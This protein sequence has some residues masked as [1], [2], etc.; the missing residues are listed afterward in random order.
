MKKTGICAALAAG[1]FVIA[2]CDPYAYGPAAGGPNQ[3]IGTIGGA[4]AGGLIGNQI[5]KG[6]GRA[7]ATTIGVIAGGLIGN[8]IG[9]NLDELD[10]RRAQEAEFRAL[11]FGR[12]GSPVAWRNPD[13]GRYGEV[14]PAAP[15]QR[16][17]Q[18]CRDYT[19]TIYIDGQPEVARGTAC[20][21]PDGTW[22]TG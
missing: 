22:S 11:E 14:V 12:S 19:H 7:V 20:R 1:A 5:G 18:N 13:S 17:G 4:V 3:A 15:Y 9:A 6:E 16:G 21:R 8:Q 2:G 10:R